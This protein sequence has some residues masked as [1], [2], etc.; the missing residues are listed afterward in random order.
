MGLD[1]YVPRS[2]L[3][4]GRLSKPPAPFMLDD[5]Y[6]DEEGCNVRSAYQVRGNIAKQGIDR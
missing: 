3:E 4:R 5:M 1:A 2:C 6:R